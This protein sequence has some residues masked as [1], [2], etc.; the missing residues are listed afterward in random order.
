MHKIYKL[1][2]MHE[3]ETVNLKRKQVF[4]VVSMFIVFS[5]NMSTTFTSVTPNNVVEDYDSDDYV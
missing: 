1:V 2:Q 5:V 3:A 4:V